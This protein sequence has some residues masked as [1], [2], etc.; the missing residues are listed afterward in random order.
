MGHTKTR[1]KSP[2]VTEDT[3]FGG[4]SGGNAG[5]SGDAVGGDDFGTSTAVASGG[6]SWENAA[7]VTSSGW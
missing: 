5:Y 4:G 6:G 7:K 3:G 1:C 2:L